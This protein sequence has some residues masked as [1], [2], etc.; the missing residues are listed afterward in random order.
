MAVI[1]HP[2]NAIRAL[3]Q[4]QLRELFTGQAVSWAVMGGPERAVQVWTFSEND[5]ARQVFDSAILGSGTLASEAML[6]SDP[7]QN[8]P[9]E[10]AGPIQ[11]AIGYV[12][13][14]WLTDQVR[15]LE[16]APDLR[17]LLRQPVLALATAEP[18]AAVRRFLACLQ[19]GVGQEE[20]RKKYLP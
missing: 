6:A 10:I 3:D 1:V 5:D 16:L 13:G 19:S 20:L 4:S 18:Q 11:G 17:A 9:R 15:A 2:D 8:D 12:P 14:A 7:A